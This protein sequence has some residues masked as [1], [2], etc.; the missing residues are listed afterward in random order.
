MPHLQGFGEIPDISGEN[1]E[2][3][4]RK[5]RDHLFMLREQLTYVL[6]NLGRD[7][8]SEAAVGE[9]K[10]EFNADLQGRLEDDEQNIA[11]L[12]LTAKGLALSFQDADRRMSSME[13]NVEGITLSVRD[14]D[15]NLSSVKLK[16]GT[17]DLENLVFSLLKEGGKTVIDG[18]NIKT[19]TISAI[20]ID[21][22]TITGSTL[23][24]LSDISRIVI[25]DGA[26]AFYDHN[27]TVRCGSLNYDDFGNVGLHSLNGAHIVID[28][29]RKL[30]LRSG[31]GIYLEGDVYVN[32][33]KI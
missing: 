16:S 22:V 10:T 17:L 5:I 12:S 30:T 18:G 1:V 25:D 24:S 4:L 15:G 11:A 31:T 13:Q 27:G 7:N 26:V 6:S 29:D 9:L 3:S 19:G 20:A 32:G 14:Q 28:S 2:S 21:G 8:L 33:V 23:T